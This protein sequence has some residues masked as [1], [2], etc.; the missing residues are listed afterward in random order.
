MSRHPRLLILVVLATVT[1]S[2][3]R[4]AAALNQ[5]PLARALARRH[6]QRFGELSQFVP[7]AWA[8]NAATGTV[9]TLTDEH[10]DANGVI[11]PDVL[12]SLA[13]RKNLTG[14]SLR[15]IP[16]KSLA[17]LATLKN[18][19]RY[20]DLYGTRTDDASLKTVA[21][22]GQLRELDLGVTRV[23]AAGIA[24]LK[25]LGQLSVLDL[26]G[27]RMTDQ[28]ITSIT[29]HRSLTSIRHLSL[30]GTRVTDA[31]VRQLSRLPRLQALAL[32][33]T[34][35]E[36]SS[37]DALAKL[38][39]LLLLDLADTD[40]T[41]D[42]LARLADCRRLQALNLENCPLVIDASTVH[43]VQLKSLRGLVLRKTGF[44]KESITGVGLLQIAR[45]TELEHLNLSATR[46]QD[47]S[48]V[49]LTRLK[50]L[51]SVNLGLTGLTNAGLVHLAKLPKLETLAVMYQEGFG[52]TKVTAEGL[53]HLAGHRTLR[54][55]DLTG[56]RIGDADLG[57][58]SGLSRL[59][60]LTISGTAITT[61][62]AAKLALRLPDCQI[63]R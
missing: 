37:L 13:L 14:L 11:K 51:R 58:F 31:G 28:A 44:E 54:D 33:G 30:S 19:L 48:L 22:L 20:L 36:G 23:T 32:A 38:P 47:D 62:G 52:G 18:T 50:Q 6:S 1:P 57:R 55:L 39:T 42:S 35:I 49:P 25:T 5:E 17:G 24:S 2:D 34:R 27:R 56:T 12:R 16:V 59:R 10:L 7:S 21:T 40:I 15:N 53:K 46:I 45:L 43:L 61:A 63:V 29:S 9:I 8:K 60:R 3:S 4:A 41:G 26:S